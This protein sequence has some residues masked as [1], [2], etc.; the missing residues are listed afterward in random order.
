MTSPVNSDFEMVEIFF[1]RE[2]T[3]KKANYLD[4]LKKP[5]TIKMDKHPITRAAYKT[6]TPKSS[7]SAAT[8]RVNRV[9]NNQNG[10]SCGFSQSYTGM[11]TDGSLMAASR[12]KAMEQ[13]EIKKGAGYEDSWKVRIANIEAKSNLAENYLSKYGIKC[14][15]DEILKRTEKQLLIKLEERWQVKKE[16]QAATQIQKIA[17]MYSCYRKHCAWK[18]IRQD[19]AFMIQRNY[20]IWRLMT[21]IP[22]T[23]REHKNKQATIVQKHMKGYYVFYKR[24]NEIRKVKMDINYAYFNAMRTKLCNNA[25]NVIKQTFMTYFKN[26]PEEKQRKFRT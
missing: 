7:S 9:L 25:Q 10:R 4:S 23:W 17:R 26:M 20:K 22:R 24:Q 3:I 2:E 21:M 8:Y 15:E 19:K 14:T 16:Y 11:F 1:P 12:K 13:Q 18:Q 5:S 6:Q